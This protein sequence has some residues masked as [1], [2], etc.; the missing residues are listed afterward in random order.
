MSNRKE[1]P[2]KLAN[3]SRKIAFRD[4]V[5]TNS[6]LE[7]MLTKHGFD[8]ETYSIT[9]GFDENLDKVPSKETMED[10]DLLD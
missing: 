7:P 3:L 2:N 6:I 4:R 9:V 1:L 8:N 5:S 10:F